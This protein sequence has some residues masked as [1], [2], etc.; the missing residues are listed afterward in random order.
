VGVGADGHIVRTMSR[1]VPPQVI[2]RPADWRLGDEAPWATAP[3]SARRDISL[4]R[5]RA[6][7]VAHGQD[8]PVPEGIGAAQ[9]LVPAVVIDETEP[10]EGDRA[11]NAAVLAVLFEGDGEARLIFTRRS[12]SL[13]SHRGEVSF[14]G[15]RLD[16]GENPPAA[17]LRE[18]YEEISLDPALVT[19]EGWIHP[20]LTVVTGSL[21]MPIVASV[22]ARPHLVASPAEVERVFDVALRDLADLENFHEERWRLGERRAP[23]TPDDSFTIWFFEVEGE[24]IWGAT[25][26]MIHELLNV[27][28]APLD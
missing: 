23:G 7:L 5:V 14:P 25:A 24:M 27:V 3:A 21:I 9:I 20:V 2:P 11:I 13:R 8:G 16:E 12:T 19:M 22:A 10:T 15:G 17:A 1:P 28:L 4:A 18:A 26:R 6:A